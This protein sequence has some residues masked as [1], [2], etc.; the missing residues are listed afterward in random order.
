MVDA[1]GAHILQTCRSVP[2]LVPVYVVHR[3]EHAPDGC[4]C[5]EQDD[6]SFNTVHPAGRAAPSKRRHQNTAQALDAAHAST[7]G[8]QRVQNMAVRHLSAICSS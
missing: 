5:L 8:L 1:D 6:D 7:G 3:S 2:Q 4:G